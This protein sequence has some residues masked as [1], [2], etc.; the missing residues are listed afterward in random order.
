MNEA[1]GKP[2]TGYGLSTGRLEAL[3]D[4]VLAIVITILVLSF[5]DL[6]EGIKHSPENSRQQVWAYLASLWPH[7][8]GYVLSFILIAIYWIM[9]HIMFHYIRHADR[10]LLWL[11]LL[12][13]MSV[14]FIPF[15]TDLL[16]ECIFHESN[17]IVALYGAVHCVTGLSLVAVWW[18][19]THSH[20]LVAADLDG[21]TIRA[22]GMTVVAAP[23]L[24]LVGIGASF[25]SIPLGIAVYAA[26]PLLYVFPGNLDRRW[27]EMAN[28]RTEA[29]GLRGFLMSGIRG[30]N[31]GSSGRG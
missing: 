30:P 21:E 26:I 5:A 20:R 4:G 18:Y 22:I 28:H 25:V 29:G 13:L 8:L 19:A 27:L 14:A 1:S 10:R 31:A 3:S 12:F 6:D 15:P 2:L 17:G 23:V 16:A 24:Y 9:H 11:N 7:V